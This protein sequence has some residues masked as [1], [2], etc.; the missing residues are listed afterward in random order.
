[1]DMDRKTG[2]F[3]L[4]EMLIS[5]VL[6]GI[7]MFGLEGPLSTALSSYKGTKGKQ[8]LL[9]KARL[10]TERMVMFVQ[11]T[12]RIENPTGT[13]EEVLKIS[14]RLLDTYNNNSH[15]Y[16]VAGDGKLDADNNGDGIVNVGTDDS[17]EYITYDLD[18][19]DS[20]NW[21]L[22]EQLPDY[23]SAP[24]GLLTKKVVCE[25]VTEFKVSRFSN[26]LVEIR[27]SVNEGNTGLS[28]QTRA[29][30]RLME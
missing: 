19:S 8:D 13:N 9:V 20:A 10:A 7:I 2:G 27:L 16:I 5:I 28:L 23:S 22:M 30:A 14:E 12:D 6:L 4:M 29:R 21:K 15:A 11:K 17:V 24:S 25:H 1:M 26:S 3:T 18:K